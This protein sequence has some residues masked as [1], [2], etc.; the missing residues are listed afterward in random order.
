MQLQTFLGK[1][2][3]FYSEIDYTRMPRIYESI[4]YKLAKPKIIHLIGTNAKG[5]TGRFL[6]SALYKARFSVG[7]YTSPHI[8]KFNERV[9][10]DGSDASDKVLEEAHKKLQSILKKEDSDSLSYFEYTTL[11][12]LVVFRRCEFVVMEAGL[13]GEYDATAV[14]DKTLTLVTPIAYDHQAFLGETIEEIAATKLRAIQNHAILATQSDEVY[15]VA[16]ELALKNSLD[17]KK[18]QDFLNFEDEK[19]IQKIE[20]ELKLAS[21][22]VDNLSLSI[23]ALKFLGINYAVEDFR[24]AKLFGRLSSL[25]E[26]IIVDVGHNPLAAQAIKKALE[27]KKYVLVY[28]SYKDKNHLEILKILKPIVH[29]VELI[30]INDNRAQTFEVLKRTLN[31]LEIEY[32]K[33]KRV[34]K[35]TPYLVFG[36]FSVVEAFM[37]SYKRVESKI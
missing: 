37:K 18:Y 32:T 15:G 5:T 30:E 4:K 8:L 28:N 2:P 26:N 23:A 11:L 7:H 20:Q 29:S 31:E 17:I 13:G 27:P 6:A 14:F 1:K 12:S 3:L 33:F 35:D 10:I 36:S 16:E 21:Y 34:N 19:K 24:D 9:W 22:L 25:S